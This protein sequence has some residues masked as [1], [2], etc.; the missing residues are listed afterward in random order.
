MAQTGRNLQ[1]LT[2]QT[3]AQSRTSSEV[4]LGFSGF[5]AIESWKSPWAVF[6]SLSGWLLPKLNYPCSENLPCFSSWLFLVPPTT[7]IKNVISQF[8]F[9]S[10]RKLQLGTPEAALSEDWTSASPHTI[11]CPAQQCWWLTSWT[12][13]NIPESEYRVTT[14]HLNLL[15]NFLWT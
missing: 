15:A 3:P 6:H 5:K 8:S 13:H 9:L 1:R 10:I 7:C 11:T 4:R 14:D 12:Q 2:A